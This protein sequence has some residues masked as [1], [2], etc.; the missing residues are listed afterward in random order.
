MSDHAGADF[1]APG[2][3]VDASGFELLGDVQTVA[4]VVNRQIDGILLAEIGIGIA[5][6]RGIVFVLRPDVIGEQLEMIG[7]ALGEV[8]NQRLVI[9]MT[10]TGCFI[11]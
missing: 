8:N 2:Q 6:A 4:A 9:A 1:E 3:F 7:E 10:K 5:L 11:V